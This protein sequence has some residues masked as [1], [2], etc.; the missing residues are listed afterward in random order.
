MVCPTSALVMS[1]LGLFFFASK[2]KETSLF[3]TLAGRV[4]TSSK[5]QVEG[6]IYLGALPFNPRV[7]EHRKMIAYV[8]QE[9]ALHETSTPREALLFSARLRLPKSM[10]DEDCRE[11]AERTLIKLGLESCA[12]TLIGGRFLKGISGGEKRRVS[13]GVELTA[14]PSL[15]FLD[16]RK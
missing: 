4:P 2:Q 5:L 6:Q 16:E 13:I 9:D 10:K 15:I 8:A 1:L 11:V 12:D 14:K 7:R 3:Q